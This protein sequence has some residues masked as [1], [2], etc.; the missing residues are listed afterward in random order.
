[1][2][3]A[4]T[5]TAAGVSFA[6]KVVPGAARDCIKGL[7]GEALK[8]QVTAPPEKGK[9]NERLCA[10]LAAALGT[11]TRCV[12]VQSGHGSPRKVVVVQGL[13]ATDVV[14]RLVP[15]S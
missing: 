8:V 12:Q 11:T 6:V 4:V 9:A 3:L 5:T 13:T 14:E 1:M 15:P 10:V 2:T 7:L